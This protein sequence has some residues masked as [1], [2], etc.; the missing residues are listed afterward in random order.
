ML[1][2][3][4]DH[5]HSYY[6]AQADSEKRNSLAPSDNTLISPTCGTLTLSMDS[7]RPSGSTDTS[8]S[9]IS[10]GT[11]SNLPL[12]LG[13]GPR[14]TLVSP[15]NIGERDDCQVVYLAF[16]FVILTLIVVIFIV[17]S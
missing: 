16:F 15:I 8:S 1:Q 3:P 12:N 7:R 14:P 2:E 11:V 17:L 10:S 13:L 9:T 5:D 4:N 6:V